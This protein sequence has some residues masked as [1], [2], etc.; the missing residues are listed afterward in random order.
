MNDW[1]DSHKVRQIY[2]LWGGPSF[3][4]VVFVYPFPKCSHKKTVDLVNHVGFQKIYTHELT[5]ICST[6]VQTVVICFA[7]AYFSYVEE[8]FGL[9][10]LDSPIQN[11]VDNVQLSQI[12]LVLKKYSSMVQSWA[13]FSCRFGLNQKCILFPFE[14]LWL[15]CNFVTWKVPHFLQK[16]TCIY[17]YYYA[18][19]VM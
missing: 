2:N 9:D 12:W 19:G 16:I 1:K 13:T 8:H 14:L 7:W 4:W 5:I 10:I 15:N 11:K 18:W 6:V 3:K 17:T